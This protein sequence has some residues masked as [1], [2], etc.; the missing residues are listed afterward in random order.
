[1]KK[2][3]NLMK[4]NLLLL[5]SHVKS[6][7][8][9]CHSLEIENARLKSELEVKKSCLESDMCLKA[10]KNNMIIDGQLVLESV[11]RE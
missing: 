11:K 7:K 8:N 5:R 3:L 9:K 2:N 6:Y 10:S 4:K 1:M